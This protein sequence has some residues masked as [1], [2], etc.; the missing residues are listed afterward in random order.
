MAA[1]L[2]AVTLRNVIIPLLPSFR[3]E[4]LHTAKVEHSWTTGQGQNAVDN[5]CK[6]HLLTCDDPSNK[7]QLLCI[8]DQFLDAAHNKRLHLSCGASRCTKFREVVGGNLRIVWQE[9]S[10]ACAAKTVD[11]FMEDVDLLVSHYFAPT[12]CQDQRPTP[13]S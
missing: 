5:Y 8:I 3:A 4:D 1:S 13:P 7:E 10:N 2:A 11:S 12:L 9:I 6:M